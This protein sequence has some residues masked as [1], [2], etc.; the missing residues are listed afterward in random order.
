[1]KCG[2]LFA[3]IGGFCLG[4]EGAGLP[5]SWAVELDSHAARTYRENLKAVRLIEAS[6]EDVS[7]QSHD[8]EP[9]D[10]LHAGF[11]CQSFSQA[12]VRKGFE[13]PRG[14]LF[15]EIIRI[16]E[17]FKDKRPKVIVLEN[18]PF[19]RYGEGG[20]WF[21]ELQRAIQKAG[22]WFRPE[23]CREL[24]AFDLT[25]LPQQRTRLFMVALSM[26]HF[27]S[28]RFVFPSEKLNKSKELRNFV[29][30]D[31]V[32]DDRYYLDNE[33][34]YF[35]MISKKVDDKNC[36][37][38]LRKY[39]VRAKEPGVCPT[40]TANMGLGGHNVPF[41]MNGRGLRKLTERECLSLQGFP[42]E[43]QFPDTVPIAKRYIQAGNAVSVPVARLLAEKVRAKLKNGET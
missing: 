16:I 12:G 4:F 43:F 19:L 27:S 6:V 9:V 5:T 37:Y 10:V 20:V 2:A 26:S 1:M 38:Q 21:L 3:G 30:F 28:G 34:R 11:P 41:L 14:K 40:L 23:N 24:S 39:E 13:D 17:S 36:L 31:G 22:Y 35:K 42:K 7:A 8:L 33:N 25:D 15:F 32:V 29:D 18:S